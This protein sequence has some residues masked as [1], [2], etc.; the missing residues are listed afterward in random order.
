M[1]IYK[2]PTEQD[3][4]DILLEDLLKEENLTL[5][6]PAE[7]WLDRLLKES[8]VEYDELWMAKAE[9]QMPEGMELRLKAT[10]D[11]LEAQ[12]VL[13]ESQTAP[14]IKMARQDQTEPPKSRLKF[15]HKTAACIAVLLAIGIG[16]NIQGSNNAFADTCKTPEEAQL[17]L[18]R[19][20]VLL[21]KNG[22]AI[23]K[24][25]ETLQQARTP[26]ENGLAKYITIQ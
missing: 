6:D 10:I 18:E 12:E 3:P 13:N 24:A 5:C 11:D 23:D 20:L 17:H 26:Q 7:E 16:Y 14:V 9:S 4:K 15:W 19:A 22:K 21:S 25:E 8:K 1:K 2:K